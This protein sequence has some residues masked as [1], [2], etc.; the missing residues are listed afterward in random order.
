MRMSWLYLADA[1]AARRGTPVLIWPQSWW[2]DA[3][4]GD[5]RWH[6]RFRRSGGRGSRSQPMP[7]RQLDGLKRLRQRADLVDL[8]EDGVGGLGFDAFL[9]VLSV[10]DEEIVADEL[11]LVA[12]LVGERFFQPSPSRF[13][14]RCR[15]RWSEFGVL[16][17]ASISPRWRRAPASELS[18]YLSCSAGDASSPSCRI[19]WLR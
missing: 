18:D 9:E 2:H 16:G 8:H 4:V 11:D 6:P 10:G 5:L 1:F 7:H 19:P 3:D 17:N 14:P 12:E 13:R 15:L